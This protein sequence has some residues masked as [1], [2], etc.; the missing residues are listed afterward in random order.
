MTRKENVMV[1]KSAQ[2]DQQR[3]L[4]YMYTTTAMKIVLVS[5]N[6]QEHKIR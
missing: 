1:R 6:F 5:V 3:Y 4:Q 2:N